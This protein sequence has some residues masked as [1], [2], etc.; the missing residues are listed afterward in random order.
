M[1]IVV[2]SPPFFSHF[3]P[4][5]TLASAL[6]DA[7]AETYLGCSEAFESEVRLRGLQF[8][9]ININRNANTGQASSTQQAERERKRLQEFL[10]ATKRG[11]IET[12]R[13]QNRHRLADMLANPEELL[14]RIQELDASLRP[15]LW[16][17]DQLS[18]GATLALIAHGLRFVTF[19]PPHPL[20][21]PPSEVLYSVPPRWPSVFS[22]EREQ[23]AV[24]E[25]EALTLEQD[26]TDRFNGLLE[27]F[28]RRVESAFRSASPEL[29]LHNYPELPEYRELNSSGREHGS[30]RR[31]ARRLYCGYS[32][33]PGSPEA[34]EEPRSSEAFEASE[35]N[36]VWGETARGHADSPRR[37][38]VALGTF[39]AARDDVLTALATGLRTLF[40]DATLAIGAGEHAERLRGQV[41]PPA[42]VDSFIPQRELLQEAELFVHHGGVSSLTEGL[43]YRVPTIVMPFSSDQFNVAADLERHG[44]GAVL[45]PNHITEAGLKEAVEGARSKSALSALAVLSRQVRGR[46]PAYAADAILELLKR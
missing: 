34:P 46:G 14:E 16:V 17:V 3:F 30:A 15:D 29:I 11:P 35:T 19:C 26:F 33:S 6:R 27:P 12:L 1:R 4:L 40:P 45:N 22:V 43:Y 37:I 20:S 18:Y 44:F 39:L 41:P 21:I 9:E 2:L 38:V 31:Q 24:L 13:A 36:G 10:D 23:I 28:G 8:C 25:K 7:G 5:A 32:F 42:I